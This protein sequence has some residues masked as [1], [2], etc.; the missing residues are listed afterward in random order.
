MKNKVADSEKA[1]ESSLNLVYGV[2][3]MAAILIVFIMLI[4]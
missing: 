1:K 4:P 3:G 2:L